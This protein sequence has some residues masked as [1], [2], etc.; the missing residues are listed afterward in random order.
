MNAYI[1]IRLTQVLTLSSPAISVGSVDASTSPADLKPSRPQA[2][3]T[4]YDKLRGWVLR[5]S[6]GSAAPSFHGYH[7]V[8]ALR[9]KV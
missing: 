2:S 5:A 7:T 4:D 3:N 1:M 9:Y 6:V 8:V